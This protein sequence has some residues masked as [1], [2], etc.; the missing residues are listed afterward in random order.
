MVR[1]RQSRSMIV[2][3]RNEVYARENGLRPYAE[4][5]QPPE[6]PNLEDLLFLMREVETA[7]QLG[8]ST[9]EI[10]KRRDIPLRLGAAMLT[11]ELPDTDTTGD[12]PR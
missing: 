6:E 3:G 8:W 9:E 7:R 10:Q 1:N 11:D 2:G 12:E 5:E 4:L